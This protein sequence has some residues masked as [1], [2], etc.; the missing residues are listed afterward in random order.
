MK[1]TAYALSI[2]IGM[3]CTLLIGVDAIYV[4]MFAGE[5]ELSK[6]PWGTELGWA[7]LNKENY[8]LSGLLKSLLSWTPLLLVI[9]TSYLTKR[10]CRYLNPV[11]TYKNDFTNTSAS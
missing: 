7:Y 2:I 3:S 10:S 6:F 9:T 1:T 5:G 4:G 8:M 11:V